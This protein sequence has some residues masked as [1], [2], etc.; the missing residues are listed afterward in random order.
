M[1]LTGA[2]RLWDT[3]G[4][5]GLKGIDRVDYCL[6]WYLSRHPLLTAIAP[7]RFTMKLPG[8]V[9][10]AIRPNGADSRTLA[11]IFERRDYELE[12]SEVKRVL[13]LG[14]NVG[15]ATLFLASRFPKAEFVCVEPSPNNAAM[16]RENIRLNRLRA[17]V[18]DGA[19]GTT[20]GEATLH[21]GCAPDMYSLT[22]AEPSGSTMSVRQFSVPEILATVGWDTVDLV[23]IDI[24]GYEKKLF[25]ENTG[26]LQRVG[27]IVGEAHGHAGYGIAEVRADL[28]PLGFRVSL[29][30]YDRANGTTLFEAERRVGWKAA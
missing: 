5:L 3:S 24:E 8:R 17:T 20:D 7:A 30:N 13:D 29:R 14:A 15:L 19:I 27:R 25:R 18:Y 1:R 4:R 22:P 26:W 2:R 16:L 9:R 28:Q 12:G 6:S 23:K 11:E 21:V 10:V